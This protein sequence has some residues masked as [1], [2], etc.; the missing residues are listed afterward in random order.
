MA[1]RVDSVGIIG[2]GTMGSG[3][4]AHFANI[5]IPVLLLDIPTPN[6]PD[7]NQLVRG[8]FERMTK[9]KPAHLAVPSRGELITLGNTEDDFGRLAACDLI[10]EVIIERLELKQ[11]LMARLEQT[12]KPGAI[13]ASNTSGLPIHAIVAH[14]SADF[15]RRFIGMHFFNPPRYLKLLEL[16]PT[17][18]TDPEII[19]VITD[20][21]RD[22]LGKGVILC[23][24][25][26]NFIGNR[27]ISITGAY[28]SEY[29]LKRGYSVAEV[30]QLT[31]PLIGRPKTGTFRLTDLVGIDVLHHVANNLYDLIPHDPYR[32]LLRGEESQRVSDFLRQN[33]WLGNKTGQ[34]YYKEGQENGQRVFLSLD[35]RTLTYHNAP[36]P[37]FASVGAVRKIGPIGERLKK[38]FTFEDRAAQFVRDT[39]YFT[40]EYASYVTPEIAYTIMD[41][42]N[43]QK[44]G[45]AHEMGPFALWDALG[46]AETV[47]D[48]EARGFK[49]A[50]WV[51][52]MVATGHSAFYE[53]GRYYD[54]VTQSYQSKPFE[55]KSIYSADLHQ[56]N[57]VI[58]SNA[59]AS[60][61]DMGDGVL[62]YEFHAKMNAID[63]DIMAMGERALARLDSDFE[64][65]VMGNNGQ[66]FC[67]GANIA[68]IGIAAAQ[69]LWD[70]LDAMIRRLQKLTFDLHHAPK[71]VVTAPHQ[72]VLGGGVEMTL[73]GWHSVAD[74]E[75]Y[76][77]LVEVGVGLLPAGG[78]LKELVA[79]KI[80]P[81]MKTENAD[82]LPVMQEIFTTVA[83]AK[84]AASA[85]EAKQLGYLR[86]TDTIV[87]N[88]D[89]RLARAKQEALQLVARGQR[90]PEVEKLYA[91]GRET[92]H[93]LLIGL[94]GF[95][96]AGYATEHDVK[97]GRKIAYALC[98]G[99]LSVPT[100]VDP[101]HILDLERE[102]FLSLCGEKKTQERIMA[103]LQTG[104]PLRN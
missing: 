101:W 31:G 10:I 30:D 103:M 75:S 46:V 76:L 59:G 25:T 104:K 88:S 1:F 65:L 73:A 14:C 95:A 82:V 12:V 92:Y 7:R 6:H 84:V 39:L 37:R 33:N 44:W 72:R 93:T 57:K 47:A 67:V 52:E 3:I 28:I 70:Q 86:P 45:F 32:D 62:L 77:G 58:E 60:L 38:L 68:M 61:L 26:P 23:K 91:A 35:P 51:K 20:F 100:W 99:D 97:I 50:A 79:R 96:W 98:G 16:I 53:F 5:G 55:R 24:D 22:V 34:G 85:W 74:H 87:F 89:Q 2:A 90:P 66:D 40:L 29:A 13:I 19:R 48:M 36:E 83:T 41:V 8:L 18:Q 27:F 4:A 69:G 81:V 11:A 94:Q 78:G 71:P 64:A 80:N 56:A 42:D 102:G 63:A 21:G 9:G 15:Q 43:A 49:V 17:P 54:F